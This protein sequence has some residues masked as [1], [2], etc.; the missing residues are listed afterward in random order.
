MLAGFGIMTVGC[1]NILRV[2]YEALRAEVLVQSLLCF[3][4]APANHQK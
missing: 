2:Q 3:S 4:F 1:V